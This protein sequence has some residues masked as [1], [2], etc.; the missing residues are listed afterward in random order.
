MSSGKRRRLSYQTSE[1]PLKWNEICR[2]VPVHC[3]ANQTTACERSWTGRVLLTEVTVCSIGGTHV[4]YGNS[5]RFGSWSKNCIPKKALL[6]RSL[7]KS[8]QGMT[9]F[10]CH[11]SYAGRSFSCKGKTRGQGWACHAVHSNQP[12]HC[13]QMIATNIQA[14]LLLPSHI[15]SVSSQTHFRP[16]LF[17]L[18]VTTS[19]WEYIVLHMCSFP[20]PDSSTLTHIHVHT[21]T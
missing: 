8:L 13:G 10:K 17:S 21:Y 2:S 12:V 16:S 1:K 20:S 15:D 18:R 5:E 11:Q 19:P 6:E 9:V 14:L 3:P 7:F 4:L